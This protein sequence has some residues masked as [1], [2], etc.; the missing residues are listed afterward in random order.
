MNPWKTLYNAN[1]FNVAFIFYSNADS[2]HDGIVVKV[3]NKNNGSIKYSFELIF[4]SDSLDKKTT[5]EGILKPGEI[6][7]GSNSKLFWVPFKD[8]KTISEV[9]IK[10]CRIEFI[11]GK[12]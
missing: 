8:G 12:P 3:H 6:K 2:Y 1:G 7:T 10:G 4:R 11:R 5:V 9:G